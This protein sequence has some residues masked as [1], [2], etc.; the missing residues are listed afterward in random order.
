MLSTNNNILFNG[1]NSTGLKTSL[2][3]P[4]KLLNS[5][6]EI[7]KVSKRDLHRFLELDHTSFTTFNVSCKDI[8][9]TNRITISLSKPS[10]KNFYLN[11]PLNSS[12]NRVEI[13][14]KDDCLTDAQNC[15]YFAFFNSNE[16]KAY[17]AFS[18]KVEANF[19]G[20]AAQQ[21]LLFLTLTFNT[22]HDHYYAFTTN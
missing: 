2:K 20:S 5:L 4:Y 6:A 8:K 13:D 19:E 17:T 16:R 15:D 14:L 3:N 7:K 10:A 9:E 11:K 22:K 1:N 18:D 21:P 12:S